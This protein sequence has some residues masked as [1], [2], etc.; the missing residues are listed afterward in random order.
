MVLQESFL[1]TCVTIETL[2]AL[3]RFVT[4]TPQNLVVVT[5]GRSMEINSRIFTR[6]ELSL[7]KEFFL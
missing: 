4:V 3:M 5:L 6:I 2:T 1:K 7:I